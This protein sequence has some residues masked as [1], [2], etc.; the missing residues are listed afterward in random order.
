MVI[1]KESAYANYFLIL[2]KFLFLSPLRGTLNDIRIKIKDLHK[3]LKSMCINL[4]LGINW[5]FFNHSHTKT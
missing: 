3:S 4:I 2:R 1:F 5:T